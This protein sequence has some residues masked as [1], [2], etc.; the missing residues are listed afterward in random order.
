[1]NQSDAAATPSSLSTSRLA[2]LRATYA[3]GEPFDLASAGGLWCV[4]P[5]TAYWAA[6]RMVASGVLK[7]IAR[8]EYALTGSTTTADGADDNDDILSFPDKKL[9][10]IDAREI[11]RHASQRCRDEIGASTS[12]TEATVEIREDGPI[13]VCFSSDWHLG[14][15]ATDY[16]AFERHWDYVIN[17]PN[18][19]IGTVG[20]EVDNS[21]AFKV[22]S[23]N[24]QAMSP[25]LQAKVLRDILADF[26][27]NRK[28][29]FTCWGNHDVMRHEKDIGFSPLA[30]IKGAHVPYFNGQG[31]LTL[32]LGKVNPVEYLIHMTHFSRFSSVLNALHSH[33]RQQDWVAPN[34]D[35][36]VTAHVHNPALSLVCPFPFAHSVEAL[37]RNLPLKSAYIRTGAFKGADTYSKRFFG[38]GIIGAPTVVFHRDKKDIVPFWTANDAVA[39]MKGLEGER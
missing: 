21:Y 35:V 34:A 13:A 11:L 23:A 31:F 7:K 25:K 28:L 4:D 14:S 5:N 8:N 1:M 24:V 2:T 30:E 26:V 33:K 10:D 36:I 9:E 15:L 3:P 19:F 38:P 29:L 16:D 6:R 37:A 22:A 20:D 32:R 17:T 12:Q 39:Y 18:L 27:D